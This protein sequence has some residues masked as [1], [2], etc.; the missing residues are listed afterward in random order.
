VEA[1]KRGVACAGD[2]AAD[3]TVRRETLSAI[4]RE[5]PRSPVYPYTRLPTNRLVHVCDV[6][7]LEILV[8]ELFRSASYRKFAIGHNPEV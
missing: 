3:P 7:V 4:G 6:Q 2:V 1:E 8:H 5:T